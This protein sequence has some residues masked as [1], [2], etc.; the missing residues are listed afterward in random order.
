VILEYETKALYDGAATLDRARSIE[1][2]LADLERA[3]RS[4]DHAYGAQS[5]TTTR[6]EVT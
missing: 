6:C 2:I 4:W 1:L 3:R 5:R